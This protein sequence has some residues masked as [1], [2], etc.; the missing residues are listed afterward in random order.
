MSDYLITSAAGQRIMGYVPK[1]YETSRVFRALAQARG[2]EVDK[3][4]QT[5]DETIN[6]FFARTATWGLDDWEDELGLEPQPGFTDA[7]RQDRIVSK[8]RGY[9]TCTISL[10]ETVAEAY[11]KGKIDVVQVHTIYVIIVKFIDTTGVPTNIDDL[12]SA[13]REVV[14]AHLEILYEYN[15]LIWYEMDAAAKTW[16]QVDALVLPWDDFE[17]GG[18]LNA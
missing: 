7:E 2:L 16:D 8:L 4:R 13:V 17:T 3:L 9:G 12:K 14:P 1:Y 18:W 6:Q 5:L 15:Y 10:V 11:D